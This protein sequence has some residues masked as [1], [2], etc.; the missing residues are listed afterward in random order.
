MKKKGIGKVAWMLC[1]E[2][3]TKKKL[4]IAKRV[5]VARLLT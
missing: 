4:I 2:K 1:L 3:S 5:L